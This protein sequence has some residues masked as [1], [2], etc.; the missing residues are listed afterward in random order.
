MKTNKIIVFDPSSAETTP[1]STS[2][3]IILIAEKLKLAV[4]QVAACYYEGWNQQFYSA[5]IELLDLQE[6]RLKG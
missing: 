6:Y 4:Q 1:D 2:K 5:S 3:L